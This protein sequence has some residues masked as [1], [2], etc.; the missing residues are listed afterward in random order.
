MAGETGERRALVRSISLSLLS[1]VLDATG[2]PVSHGMKV[3][4][5]LVREPYWERTA[6]T[7]AGTNSAV[8]NFGG[9][10]DYTAGGGVDTVGDA[11]ARINNLLIE[12]SSITEYNYAWIGFRSASKH[13]TLAN[14]VPLW[15]LEDAT[16]FGNDTG[17]TIDATASPGGA[18]NTKLTCDFFSDTTWANRVWLKLSDVTANYSDNY[19]RF[20]VILR[21]KVDS[22]LVVN[23]GLHSGIIGY[24]VELGRVRV[25]ATLWTAYPLGIVE[26]PHRRLDTLDLLAASYDADYALGIN[27][28]KVSGGAG[29][30]LHMDCLHLIP[31]DELFIYTDNLRTDSDK[32]SIITQTPARVSQLLPYNTGS[33]AMNRIAK[34][35]IDG[36]GVPL[37]D[38]RLYILLADVAR[39]TYLSETCEITLNTW[40]SWATLRGSE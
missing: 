32:S 21:A 31:I 20:L 26:I 3:R 1:P 8:S 25:D 27:A 28:E 24:P 37:G 33:S 16:T 30:D 40:P 6:A 9:A 14:F 39:R 7:A 36:V 18:G 15:E 22:G 2:E 38:G 4:V 23:V 12:Q 35:N 11:P 19:G 29:L 17:V 34:V 5:A 13:G 10:F